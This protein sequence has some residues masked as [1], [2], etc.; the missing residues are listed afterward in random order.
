[1][2]GEKEDVMKKIINGRLY[3]TSTTTELG[4]WEKDYR[5]FSYIQETLYRK[6]TGEYFL[7]GE[8]GA[9]S[10]YAVAIG[11]NNWSG[12][13]KIIPLTADAAQKWAEEHL[14]ADEYM[15]IFSPVDED[16]KLTTV[17]Y[18]IPNAKAAAIKRLA[19]E[20]GITQQQLVNDILDAAIKGASS[21]AEK[22]AAKI[23]AGAEW[24]PEEC[25]Q[26]AALAGMEEEW[27]A[28]DGETFEAVLYEAAKRLG[29]EI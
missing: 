26:L 5:E 20:R 13:E 7:H 15:E 21:E 6:K 28:A 8:G 1:M 29:V 18:K 2:A 11:Q 3:D 12:G 23:R 9:A 17:T 19:H 16:E 14:T 27:K 10:K 25:E 24:I 22:L 4:N